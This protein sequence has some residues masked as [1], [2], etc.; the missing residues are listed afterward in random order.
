MSTNTPEIRTAK[1]GQ[2]LTFVLNSQLY[3]VPIGTVR[4]INRLSEITPVPK[5]P[6]FVAGVMNLRGKVIPVVNLR[7]KL[8]FERTNNT[9][10]TCIIVIETVVGQVGMI[11][12]SVR[13]V[14]ELFTNQIEPTPNLGN[15]AETEFVLGMGKLE[16][17][18]IILI[19]I[20]KALSNNQLAELGTLPERNAA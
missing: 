12:D 4:E 8:G 14:I 11:V 13:G 17:T 18:V 6:S 20:V 9:K 2:Y 15:S 1:P 3:G 10:E 19:D 5:T 7:S 16:N